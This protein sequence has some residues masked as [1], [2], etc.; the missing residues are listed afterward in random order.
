MQ[1]LLMMNS[2]SSIYQGTWVSAFFDQ[3]GDP[4]SVATGY[5]N[6]SSLGG[7]NPSDPEQLDERTIPVGSMTPNWFDFLGFRFTFG[8]LFIK[9]DGYNSIYCLLSVPGNQV[10]ALNEANFKS[11][12]QNYKVKFNSVSVQVLEVPHYPIPIDHQTQYNITT[13][14][15]PLIPDNLNVSHG[16]LEITL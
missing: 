10:T 11:V 6:I 3:S 15:L 5:T 2:K 8:Q 14:G 7:A 16:S 9:Y 12:I 4:V 1:A 13:I